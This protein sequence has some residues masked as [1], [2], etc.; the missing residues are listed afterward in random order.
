[1]KAIKAMFNVE[2]EYFHK[3][4]IGFYNNNK[5]LDLY[6]NFIG[7]LI[8]E[9]YDFLW[10][11][12]FFCAVI[13]DPEDIKTVLNSGNSFEKSP[14]LKIAIS[15]GFTMIG[16][17][18]EY[19]QHSKSLSPIF[20]TSNLRSLIPNIDKKMKQIFIDYCDDLEL[21]GAETDVK[22]LMLKFSLKTVCSSIYDIDEIDEN[23]LNE[24]VKNIETFFN[25]S[26]TNAFK[27]WKYLD[28]VLGRSKMKYLRSVEKLMKTSENNSKVIS[29]FSCMEELNSKMSYNEYLESIGIFLFG[30]YDTTGQ[31]L[32]NTILL[33]S[34]N[35]NEQE[36]VFNEISS[37]LSSSNDEITEEKINQMHYLD[38][39]IKETLR[40]F[41][42]LYFFFRK[43]TND[44][45]LSMKLLYFL[46]VLMTF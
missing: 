35:Q 41:P 24:V 23:L 22:F 19:K 5:F 31:T 4:M 46:K 6:E 2:G 36:K 39:V 21:N 14:I 29:Y 43:A 1:M 27:P 30:S 26:V 34:M 15:N 10:L 38:L 9:K 40:L 32:A 37:I 12:S 45:K 18:Q 33:L 17:I 44:L 11:W 8:R 13:H 42:T 28:F 20:K 25:N 16:D 7:P 3:F